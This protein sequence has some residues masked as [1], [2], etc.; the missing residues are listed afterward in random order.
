M[1]IYKPPAFPSHFPPLSSPL[2]PL[3]RTSWSIHFLHT[4]RMPTEEQV[5]LMEQLV[6][7]MDLNP[8]TLCLSTPEQS[9]NPSLRRCY[10]FLAQR[11][12]NPHA[13]VWRRCVGLVDV[14]GCGLDIIL[15]GGW[16]T[17]ASLFVHL[18]MCTSSCAPH[19]VHLIHLCN[20]M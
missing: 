1:V 8:G 3:P 6:D 14:Y 15:V 2:L 16:S 7:A 17:P 19:H 18:I 20:V 11:A 13:R 10:E 5:D 9:P 4:Q 12:L